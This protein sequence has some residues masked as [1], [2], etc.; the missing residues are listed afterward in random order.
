MR[1]FCGVGSQTCLLCWMFTNAVLVCVSFFFPCISFG[2]VTWGCCRLSALLVNMP[3]VS[4]RWWCFLAG[5]RFFGGWCFFA[6]VALRSCLYCMGLCV[7]TVQD[8]CPLARHTP[9]VL[10]YVVSATWLLHD[11]HGVWGFHGESFLGQYPVAFLQKLSR[12]GGFFFCLD[13]LRVIH[14]SIFHGSWR[15]RI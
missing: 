14:H 15:R 4:R 7:C 1:W 9:H 12:G 3:Y 2:C 6:G 13:R 11:T 5:W 8:I 10:M